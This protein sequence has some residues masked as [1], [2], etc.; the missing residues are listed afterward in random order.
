MIPPVFGNP[1][2][3]SG[4]ATPAS[5]P[6]PARPAVPGPPDAR[7]GERGDGSHDG[8]HPLADVLQRAT[9]EAAA[10]ERRVSRRDALKLG[11]AFGL[12]A[13][14]A[15]IPFQAGQ[16]K[17]APAPSRRIVIVGGGLAGLTCAYELKQAGQAATVYEASDRVGGHSWTLRGAFADGQ[18]VERG[19]QLIDQGHTALRQLASRLGLQTDNLLQA[20]ANG[21]EPLYHFDGQPYTYGQATQDLGAIY[22]KLHGDLSA[23]GYPPCTTPSPR[24]ASSWTGCR[25]WTGSTSGSRA[26]PA[27]SSA[28]SSR[29]PTPSSTAPTPASRAP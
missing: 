4:H 20:E 16:A 29:S 21:S 25:S 9:A 22:Q 3:P 24:G 14:A 19:G 18:L 1:A 28:S 2:L 7:A 27:P 5:G 17:P 23:A 13:A 26:G 15:A 10:Q 8:P 11:G 6:P 12:A